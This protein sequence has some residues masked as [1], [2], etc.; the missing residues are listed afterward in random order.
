MFKPLK[1]SLSFVAAAFMAA[2]LLSGCQS[3]PRLYLPGP[4]MGMQRALPQLTTFSSG[5]KARRKLGLRLDPNRRRIQVSAED[6]SGDLRASGLPVRM[7]LRQ[8]ATPI[9]DQG[10]LGACTGFSVKAARELMLVRDGQPATT[11]SPLFIYYY[12]RLQ[13]GTVDEDAGAMIT[14][15]MQVLQKQGVALEALWSYDP[16]NDNNPVTKE[17]FQL[18]PTPEANQ[19]ALQF[20]VKKIQPL[21]KLRDIRYA[22]SKRQ[23]VVIGIEVY[24]AFYDPPQGRLPIPNP[25]DQSEGGHAVTVVGYDDAEK[26]LIVK[27]SWGPAWGDQGYFYLPYEYVKL[28]LASEAWTAF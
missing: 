14:S 22:L 20:R 27:N 18:P 3:Q 17:K 11:L 6:L 13:E 24:E 15:G 8:W 21:D 5:P 26:V 10:E 1:K 28:G 9:D 19:N 16:S 2:G 23:P 4:I 7:D 12:E 25:K